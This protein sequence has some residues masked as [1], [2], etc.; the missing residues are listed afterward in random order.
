[1]GQT[2]SFKTFSGHSAHAKIFFMLTSS[3]LCPNVH[4]HAE[5]E[6]A[7]RKTIAVKLEACLF[8]DLFDILGID[9]PWFLCQCPSWCHL[10]TV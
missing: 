7:F 2:N 6:M 8:F 1:M 3:L 4:S 5:L 10:F 9:L